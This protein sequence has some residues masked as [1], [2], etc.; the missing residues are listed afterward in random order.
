MTG[1]AAGLL[2]LPAESNEQVPA[3]CAV[4]PAAELLTPLYR[5]V[6]AAAA[7][8]LAGSVAAAAAAAGPALRM[9]QPPSPPAPPRWATHM[10]SAAVL[11]CPCR[12]DAAAQQRFTIWRRGEQLRGVGRHV[13]QMPQHR[14]GPAEEMQPLNC[15]SHC[16]MTT[17]GSCSVER[18]QCQTSQHFQDPAFKQDHASLSTFGKA[19]R[20]HTPQACSKCRGRVQLQAACSM[21]GAQVP[22]VKHP[23]PSLS[24]I[25]IVV[26]RLRQLPPRLETRAHSPAAV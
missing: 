5:H 25:A 26:T 4:V 8:V 1:V 3:L 6:V 16:G 15:E 21:P 14:R 2:P 11:P 23:Q 9:P 20:C 13:C 18:H 19:F 10:S 12:G 7:V 17:T 24:I 22:P